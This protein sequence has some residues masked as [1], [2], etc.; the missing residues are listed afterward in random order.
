[1][2]EAR[3]FLLVVQSVQY[4]RNNFIINELLTSTPWII[5]IGRLDLEISYE[6]NLSF[7]QKSWQMLWQMNEI[8]FSCFILNETLMTT[9]HGDD[10]RSGLAWQQISQ[11][12]WLKLITLGC[13][14]GS[15]P[16]W[17]NSSLDYLPKWMT[18]K[19]VPSVSQENQS[20][21]HHIQYNINQL[22]KYFVKLH[23]R[24]C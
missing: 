1:M 17:L 10:K 16:L 20:T 24:E 15:H 4:I 2:E 12:W 11:G 9:D 21:F 5:P 13:S 22:K 18:E 7:N 23:K 6:C 14:S 3:A 19:P 8:W